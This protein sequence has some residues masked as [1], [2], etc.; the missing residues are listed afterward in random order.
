[1]TARGHSSGDIALATAGRTSDDVGSTVRFSLP[2]EGRLIAAALWLAEDDGPCQA[3][4]LV[5]SGRWRGSVV[6]GWLRGGGGG[7]S[8]TDRSG[9]RWYEEMVLDKARG[10]YIFFGVDNRTGAGVTWRGDWVTER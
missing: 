7:Q 1:M 3:V 10:N 9:I 4:I 6:G 8:W 2:S 5:K